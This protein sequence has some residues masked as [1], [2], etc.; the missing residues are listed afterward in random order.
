[1][2]IRVGFVSN[3]SSSSFVIVTTKENYDKTLGEVH[4]FI[5]AIANSL[6]KPAGKFLGKDLV[7][8]STFCDMNGNSTFDDLEVDYNGELPEGYTE[9]NDYYYGEFFDDFCVKL[10]AKEDEIMIENVDF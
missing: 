2:K 4:P 1:M 5:A 3:S 7:K 8:A 10:S 6:F 9:K